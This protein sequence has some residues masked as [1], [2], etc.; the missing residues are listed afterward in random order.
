METAEVREHPAPVGTGDRREG[1]KIA[2][3]D[4]G[5]KRNCEDQE[6]RGP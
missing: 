6:R 4:R 3:P 2:S 1:A 5:D